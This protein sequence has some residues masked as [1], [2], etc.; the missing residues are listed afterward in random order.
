MISEDSLTALELPAVLAQI[1][2]RAHT[3]TGAGAALGLRPL[4]DAAAL[5]TAR[6]RVHEALRCLEEAGDPVPSDLLE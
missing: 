6:Q 3:P 4:S 1:A 2:A 5:E